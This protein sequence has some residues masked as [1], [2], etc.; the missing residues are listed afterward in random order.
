[1]SLLR[2]SALSAFLL[3]KC[4]YLV[5][6]GLIG[7]FA[8][9]AAL[10]M[11]YNVFK[12]FRQYQKACKTGFKVYVHVFDTTNPFWTLFATPL[13]PVLRR[14]LPASA[15]RV[16][17]LTAYG[18]EW[19]DKVAGRTRFRPGYMIASP[20]Y[21]LDLFVEDPEI[22]G[23]ILTRWR[24]FPM[25]RMSKKFMGAVGPNMTSSDGKDWQR[26]RR[27]I[28]PM[29]NERIMDTV[30]NESVEQAGDM[31]EAFMGQDGGQTDRTVEGVRRIAFNV[32]QCIGYGMPQGW[33]E[34]DPAPSKG[35]KMTYSQAIAELIEGLVLVAMI[36]AK[37]LAK[38]WLPDGI[39]RKGEA[40]FDFRKYTKELLAME[41]ELSKTSQEPRNSML[42]MLANISERNA[43]SKENDSSLPKN[44]LS[45]AEIEG[46]LYQF[47]LAGYD[48]TANTMAYAFVML[49]AQ[50][51]WQDWIVEEIDHVSAAAP[52]LSYREVFPKL[53]RVLALMV[54][55]FDHPVAP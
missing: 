48:T 3:S 40:I 28:A 26:Q 32:L 16:V 54:R 23:V 49:A 41:R 47:T 44:S 6:M 9:A 4:R 46:N 34:P 43:E 25:D 10:Y 1:M 21:E 8:A 45:D 15:V 18:F 53:G 14:I 22:A 37:L 30:W 29:L 5:A 31:M 35:H 39:R 52:G 7:F 55:Y 38:P 17:E 2:I 20:G 51:E 24:E 13:L 36:P 42:N 19:R 12:I 33:N 11:L 27:L 50:P